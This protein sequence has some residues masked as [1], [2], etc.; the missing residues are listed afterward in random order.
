MNQMASDKSCLVANSNLIRRI[1]SKR[2]D[3]L[4]DTHRFMKEIILLGLNALD[5]SRISIWMIEDGKYLECVLN[6]EW[7]F[8]EV[9]PQPPIIEKKNHPEYFSAIFFG[10]SIVVNDA[11]TDERTKSFCDDYLKPQNIKSMLDTIIFKEGFPIGVVCC[12][13]VGESRE[14]SV[15]EVHFTEVLADCCTYRFMARE[16]AKL[17]KKLETLAFKDELTGVHNRRFFFESIDVIFNQH[18]REKQP[19]SFAMIDLDNFKSINDKFGHE[20]GDLVLRKFAEIVKSSLRKSDLF[21]RLGGE[22]FVIAF[23]GLTSDKAKEVLERISKS[24]HDC[25]IVYLNA[26]VNFT[27]SVGISQLN[28]NETIIAS[29]RHADEAVYQ[30][31]KRGKDQVFICK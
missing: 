30:A 17:E 27:F 18:V 22:E 16:Q 28:Y 11:E 12:E 20:A 7:Y 9:P 31:K 8:T 23:Q 13:Q 19:L 29:I 3:L 4:T 25:S 15:E 10:N 5:V 2:E 14:W 21:C 26:K 6:S 24:V 1:A